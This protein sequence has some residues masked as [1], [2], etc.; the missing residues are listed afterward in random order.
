M[1]K[2]ITLFEATI[3]IT[4]A[5]KTVGRTDPSEAELAAVEEAQQCGSFLRVVVVNRDVLAAPLSPLPRTMMT[6]RDGFST[7]HRFLRQKMTL[8]E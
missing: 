1:S 7:G 2:L 8:I 4:Q 5:E 3:S 6:R